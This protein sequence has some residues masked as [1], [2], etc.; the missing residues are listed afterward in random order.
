VTFEE[1]QL[2]DPLL[3]AVRQEG[4][5]RPTPVQSQAIP[6]AIAGRDV[7]GIA[8]TGTGKTAA[9]ALPILQHLAKHAPTRGQRPIRV[10]VLTPTRELASQIADAF[11]AYG[12]FT[13]ARMAVIF[14]G[15]GQRP[16]ELALR[17]GVDV[18]VAC[19]GRLL[20]LMNQGF[21]DL[22]A[23]EV[24][25]LDEADRMLDMGFLPDVRRVVAKLP[26]KRQTLFFSAT[27]PPDI[28]Q[29][30]DGLLKDAAR[31]EVTPVATTAETVTQ[32]LYFVEKG[33]KRALLAHLLRDPAMS[34]VLVFSRTKHGANR[35]AQDLEKT[36]EKA[37]AIHGNKSQGARER[38]LEGFRKG[39]LRVLVATDIAARGIDV[40]EVSHVVNFDLPNVPETYVHRIGRT[41]R[42]GAR[43]E[44]ISFCDTEEREYL[45]DIERLTRVRIPRVAEHPF[46][47]PSPPPP[48]TSLEPRRGFGHI[49]GSAPRPQQPPQQR[50]QPRGGASHPRP[51]PVPSSRPANTSPGARSH[52]GRR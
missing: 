52:G 11:T 50:P 30:A 7:L 26:A 1:L 9:F 5:T 13:H 20:D 25:V 32:K 17:E 6:P 48:E 14:G 41:G 38:A 43:G 24:F 29:L 18:L 22:R 16:Q 42:A 4:Y 27:M 47:S 49:N 40:E 2:I 15:V 39:T 21:V 46:R 23:L 33:E 34:R 28:Q 45:V 10:L 3:R 51:H 31:V 12:R 8:Q 37:A 19:P 35:I 36:G 44:S